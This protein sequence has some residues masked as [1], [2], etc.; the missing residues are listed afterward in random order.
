M[1][2]CGYIVGPLQLLFV[3]YLS[4]FKGLDLF[5]GIELVFWTGYLLAF[6]MIPFNSSL[7]INKGSLAIEVFKT[8][9]LSQLKQIKKEIESHL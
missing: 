5:Y 7:V 4:F 6:V 8:A 2:F 1:L 3:V 9:K